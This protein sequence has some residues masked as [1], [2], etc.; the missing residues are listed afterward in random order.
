[1]GNVN[2]MRSVGRQLLDKKDQINKFTKNE[3]LEDLLKNIDRT[4]LSKEAEDYP[5][6]MIAELPTQ[7]FRKNLAMVY[8]LVLAGEGLKVI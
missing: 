3:Q 7:C 4:K 8:N 1:M 5:D 2:Q 6:N